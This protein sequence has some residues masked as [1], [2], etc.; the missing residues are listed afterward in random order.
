MVYQNH[1]SRFFQFRRGVLPGS[2]LGPVFFPFFISD[3]PASLLSSVRCSLYADDLAIWSSSTSV[4]AAVEATQ[5]AVIAQVLSASVFSIRANVRPPPSQWILTNP[6]SNP[7]CTFLTLLSALVP[8]QLFL[9]SPS[10]AHFPFL[11]MY[12]R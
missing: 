6:T 12:L 8:L 9:W 4:P 10:I 11:N 2:V 1:K 7:I 3:L 5:G